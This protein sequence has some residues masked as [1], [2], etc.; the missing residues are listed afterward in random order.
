MILVNVSPSKGTILNSNE[1]RDEHF[2]SDDSNEEKIKE[3]KEKDLT[4]L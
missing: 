4:N 2:E 1:S 3:F